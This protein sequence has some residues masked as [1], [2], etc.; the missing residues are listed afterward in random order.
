[1]STKP[2]A[3]HLAAIPF[4]IEAIDQPHG[5]GF[6]GIDDELLLGAVAT[7]VDLAQRKP[8]R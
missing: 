1:M 7:L 2:A 4:E 8:E 3:A 6:D 5:L